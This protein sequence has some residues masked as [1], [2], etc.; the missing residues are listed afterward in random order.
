MGRGEV[1]NRW[2]KWRERKLWSECT[3]VLY[4]RVYFQ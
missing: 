2:E 1:E 3:D 4:V